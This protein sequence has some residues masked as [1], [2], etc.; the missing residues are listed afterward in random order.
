MDSLYASIDST[1]YYE[2]AYGPLQHTPYLF[3]YAGVPTKT[4]YHV[5]QIRK[6]Y[7][8]TPEGL[9]GND[10]YGQLSTW[11]VFSAIGFYPVNPCD[12]KYRL[13]T[14]LFKKVILKLGQ[15]RRFIIKANKENDQYIYV[16]KILL[17]GDPLKRPWITHEEI[18]RGGELE[19]ILTDQPTT[20][21]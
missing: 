2:Q 8:D 20:N 14:P 11:Y 6:L 7:S 18:L 16:K 10:N 19:F 12:G 15:D 1:L 3:S 5:S 9:P 17:N 21:L 4:Q 13:G